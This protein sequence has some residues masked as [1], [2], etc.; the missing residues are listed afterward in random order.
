MPSRLSPS[1]R[2]LQRDGAGRVALGGVAQK[3]WRV[4]AAE[5]ELPLGAKA[6]AA[7]CSPGARP[8]QENAFKLTLAERMLGGGSC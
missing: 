5:G 8:T 6:A 3:P 7:A 2:S 1:R 4:E